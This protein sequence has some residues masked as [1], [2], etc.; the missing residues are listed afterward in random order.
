MIW[1]PF[2]PFLTLILWKYIHI[3]HI[4]T[5]TIFI[6]F[7]YSIQAATA[8]QNLQRAQHNIFKESEGRRAGGGWV[9]AALPSP[10]V[11]LHQGRLPIRAHTYDTLDSPA[12]TMAGDNRPLPAAQSMT[13]CPRVDVWL[14]IYLLYTAHIRIVSFSPSYYVPGSKMSEFCFLCWDISDNISNMLSLFSSMFKQQAINSRQ[15][16]GLL[17]LL[18]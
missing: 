16:N 2:V 14:T 9:A 5:S 18:R 4:W 7:F 1:N 6:L 12:W 11:S 17:S 13:Y 10:L 8:P 15:T 3:A